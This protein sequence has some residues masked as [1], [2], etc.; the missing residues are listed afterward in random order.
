M[1]G[2]Q[3]DFGVLR[4]HMSLQGGTPPEGFAATLG[5]ANID[6]TPQI[7]QQENQAD[8]GRKPSDEANPLGVSPQTVRQN[9]WWVA[10][11]IHTCWCALSACMVFL[12][13]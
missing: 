4:V 2:V 8:V 12:A 9:V 6:L 10:L 3:V 7:N 1:L 11:M 5:V 13:V